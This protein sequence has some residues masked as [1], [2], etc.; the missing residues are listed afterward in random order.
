LIPLWC[1]G[2]SMNTKLVL[3]GGAAVGLGAILVMVVVGSGV[4]VRRSPESDQAS[5]VAP[6]VEFVHVHRDASDKTGDEVVNAVYRLVNGGADPIAFYGV[7]GHWPVGRLRYLD[8]GKC[9]DDNVFER[10]ECGFGISVGCLGVGEVAEFEVRVDRPNLPLEVGVG[11]WDAS[12]SDIPPW[13]E[14]NW[15]WADAVII[16]AVPVHLRGAAEDNLLDRR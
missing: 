11:T 5:L 1:V 10:L 3:A 6:T 13:E 16:D 8:A 15:S 2:L 12:R 9:I 7:G 14:W 4:L